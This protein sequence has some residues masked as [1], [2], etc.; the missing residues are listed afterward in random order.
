MSLS[1]FILVALT[2]HALMIFDDFDLQITNFGLCWC[3]YNNKKWNDWCTQRIHAFQF[4]HK[5]KGSFHLRFEFHKIF[6]MLLV[7]FDCKSKFDQNCSKLFWSAIAHLFSFFFFLKCQSND[8]IQIECEIVKK[9]LQ[10]MIRVGRSLFAY[11]HPNQKPK[12]RKIHM[13]AT[14]FNSDFFFKNKCLNP[15][16]SEYFP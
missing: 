4:L 2:A 12:L 3:V 8:I 11:S 16:N 5:C 15:W 6:I 7:F 14:K 1:N 9:S 10:N 13:N